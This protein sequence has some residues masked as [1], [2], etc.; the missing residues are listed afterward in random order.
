VQTGASDG[1]NKLL[2]QKANPQVDVWTSIESTVTAATGAGLLAKI[3]AAAIPNVAQVPE[4]L[5][6]ETGV[7]IWLSPRG[8]FYRKD[9]VP[10]PIKRWE[11]L[12]DPRLKGKVGTTIT[13]DRG[14]FLVLAALLNGGSEK[15]IDKGFEKMAALKDNLHAIYKTD[16]ESIKLLETG[17]IAVAG[18][19]I[20]PNVYRHLGPE[21]KYEFVMP[22]PR[23]LATIPVSIVAGRGDEQTKAAQQFVNLM[24]TPES[25][26]IMTSIAGTIPA[27]PKAAP[28][29]KLKGFLPPLPIADV[30]D[31]DWTVVNANYAKWEERWM[32]EVQV[33]R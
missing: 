9:L 17:E 14:N 13:L 31:V 32:Q 6:T 10:F 5:R 28:P 11:D 12:W 1:M 27:N 3:D 33:R 21:S 23:F 25:Q 26:T 8:I 29:E 2:A 15:A 30:Y 7:A 4:K 19:G 24:L 20:L 18:W 16:P 22:P